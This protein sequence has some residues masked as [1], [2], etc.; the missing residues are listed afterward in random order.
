ML[1]R[2]TFLQDPPSPLRPANM[3]SERDPLLPQADPSKSDHPKHPGGVGPMEISRS[4]R[5]GILAGIWTASFLSVCN[6]SATHLMKICSKFHL[7]PCATVLEQ[8]VQSLHWSLNLV[9]TAKLVTR[10]VATLVATCEHGPAYTE[11]V[12]S[13]SPCLSVAVDLVRLQQGPPGKLAR[14]RVRQYRLSSH[15]RAAQYA[16]L[17][18]DTFMQILAGDVHLHAA[19]WPT[20][21]CHGTPTRQPN[22]RVLCRPGNPRVWVFRKYGDPHRREIRE[23]SA[24]NPTNLDSNVSSL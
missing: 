6:N 14:N 2:P 4:M 12:L 3:P 23:H 21:Q 18:T 20:V 15:C 17:L 8:Y 13:E 16:S 9:L 7:V 1:H 10:V 11:R 19:V 22:G 24:N 5:Y